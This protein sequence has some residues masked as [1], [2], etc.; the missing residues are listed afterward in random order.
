MS[1]ANGESFTSFPI[2]IPFISFSSL[3]AVAKTS[4][5]C[6]MVVMRVGTIVL[7]LTLGE[8][9]SIFHHWGCLLW[10][11]HIWLLLSWAMFLLC[12]SFCFLES[13]CHK[14]MLNFVKA[15]LCLYWDCHMVFIFQFF[16]A[17]Y[18]ID[19]FVNIEDSLHLWD[20]AHL[21]IMYDLFNMLLDSVCYNI[22]EDFYI[23]IHQWYWPVVFCLFVCLFHDIFVWF[24]Y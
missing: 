23:Y 1:S 8:M 15:F 11:Y 17:A 13:F 4:K 5:L 7:F 22:A 12:L 21:V 16:D 24:W 14:W 10:I 20:E 2:W 9:F 3:I 18:H 19:W 6:W